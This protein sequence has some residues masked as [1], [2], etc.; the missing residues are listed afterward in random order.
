MTNNRDKQLIRSVTEITG[1]EIIASSSL[2]AGFGMTGLRAKLAD[3]REIAVK[4]GR[5]ANLELEAYMLHQLA[6]RSR[7]PTPAIYHAAKGLLIIEWLDNDGRI[8]SGTEQHAAEI[9]AEFH[10][11]RF[12]KCGYERNTLIGPLHQ[13][14]PYNDSW[15][16]FFRQS[17]L[18]YMASKALEEGAIVSGM[19]SR[20]EKLAER[21]DEYLVEP[22]HPSMLHG[23]L[24]TG[25]ILAK[26]GKIVGFI[27]PAIYCGHCEIEL[28][29]TTMFGTFGKTFF[30]AYENLN[31][32]E[33]GFHELRCDIYNIYPGLVHVRLF[34][35]SYLPPI[36]A[37]LTRLGF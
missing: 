8:T 15:I 24:W 9:L 33:P 26:N 7:L 13:P 12:E 30:D 18:L 20:L 22:K 23:D 4:A 29:F 1:S 6:T 16:A 2:G 17:R 37:L 34:G 27:D 25:N 31:P 32:L 21:L 19:F 3:G 10:S 35:A 14:N 28:A 11:L 36:H 5:G